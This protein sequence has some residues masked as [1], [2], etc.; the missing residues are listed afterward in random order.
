MSVAASITMQCNVWKVNL[1]CKR[2]WVT[3]FCSKCHLENSPSTFRFNLDMFTLYMQSNFFT[4]LAMFISK[5]F[6]PS[7]S[8]S[9]WRL[10]KGLVSTVILKVDWLFMISCHNYYFWWKQH[11]PNVV[12]SK[13]ILYKT[14]F[15]PGGGGDEAC[16]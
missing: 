1:I 13:T 11:N 5:L 3:E 4:F 14:K 7:I 2:T 10:G 12:F 6:P 16:L 15:F 8:K 9:T